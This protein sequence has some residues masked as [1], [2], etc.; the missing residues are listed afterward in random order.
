MNDHKGKTNK[1]ISET[2]AYLLQHAYNPV[3]WYPWGEEALQKAVKE[4]KPIL[5]SIGYAACHWCHVMERESFEDETTAELMNKLFINIKIDR[6]ERPDLDHIYMDAVQ[7][8]AGNGGWPLNVFLTPDQKPFYGGTYFPPV[9]AHGRPSWKDVLISLADAWKNKREELVAQ[10]DSLV[11]HIQKSGS[12]SLNESVS[13]STQENFYNKETCV[14]MAESFLKLAD[15]TEGGFGAPP[16]F[17]QTG[18]IIYLL[19]H[20]QFCSNEAAKEQAVLSLKKMINGGIYDQVGGGISRYS[21]DAFWLVPHFEKML[22]DNALLLSA[23]SEALQLTG[24]EKFRK[25]IYG[26]FNF[27]LREMKHD[28]GGFYAALDADSEGVEGLFYIWSYDEIE[29]LLGEDAAIYASYYNIKKE[30]NIP[31]E[32][33]AWKEKNILHHDF[34]SNDA[35]ADEAVLSVIIDKCNNVLLQARSERIRP[36][37]DDKILLGW[38]ALLITAFCKCYA[39]TADE[40]FLKE[41]RSLFEFIE[42]SFKKDEFLYGHSFTKGKLKHPAYLE[43]HAYYLQAMIYLSEATTDQK[44]IDRADQ[45]LKYVIDHFSDEEV[46]QFYF[47]NKKQQDIIIRKKE[48]FDGATPSPNA[49]MAENLFYLGLLRAEENLTERAGKMLA[50]LKHAFVKYPG[51]FS[52]WARIYQLQAVG[53]NEILV[54]GPDLQAVTI[55]ILQKYLPNKILTA[56]NNARKLN[57][58]ARKEQ[59]EEM[60]IYICRNKTCKA[61]VSSV[62]EIDLLTTDYFQ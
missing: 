37:T 7:A 45:I 9:P 20:A 51:S 22:Y 35:D 38:N 4:D 8:I 48:I 42:S 19:Q 33:K 55:K 40:N 34:T 5:V 1:L 12:F 21:T 17:L 30:G 27:L 10:A 24:D 25:T 28:A 47:T 41:A 39:A 16:K 61:P 59:N 18:S 13:P 52:N 57:F 46:I 50:I 32:H 43:D 6:E 2:S 60:N 54:S 29:Q 23:L 49:V 26:I 14:S 11:E 62:S 36:Q 56:V 31:P 44:Y 15:K 3:D 53:I 58:I